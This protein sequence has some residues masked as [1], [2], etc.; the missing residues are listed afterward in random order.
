M[1]KGKI[2]NKQT[3]EHD[4]LAVLHCKKCGEQ[5]HT[6]WPD[7]LIEAKLSA[8]AEVLQRTKTTIATKS[9]GDI[10]KEAIKVVEESLKEVKEVYEA[11][12]QYQDKIYRK[13]TATIR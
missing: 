7:A 6:H 4:F 11:T 12:M 1:P 10:H 5:F 8:V 3:C 2:N 9:R 13:R